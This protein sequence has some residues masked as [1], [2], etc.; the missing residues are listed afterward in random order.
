MYVL[1]WCY[2]LVKKNIITALVSPDQMTL[3][4]P[5]RFIGYHLNRLLEDTE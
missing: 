4:T 2:L 3:V 5:C 1:T